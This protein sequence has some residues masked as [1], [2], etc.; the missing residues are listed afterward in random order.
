[1]PNFFAIIFVVVLLPVPEP[2]SRAITKFSELL[3]SGAKDRKS[4]Q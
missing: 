2:P 3:M 4:P 1:M